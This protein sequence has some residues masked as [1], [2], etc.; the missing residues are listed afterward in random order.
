MLF[1]NWNTT[2]LFALYFIPSHTRGGVRISYSS[3]SVDVSLHTPTLSENDGSHTLNIDKNSID[4]IT[5]IIGVIATMK[6]WSII[7]NDKNRRQI[8]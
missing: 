3:K 4:K 1:F 7:N 5:V 6:K 2:R 8:Y